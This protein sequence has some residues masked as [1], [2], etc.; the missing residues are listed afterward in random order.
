MVSY[1]WDTRGTFQETKRKPSSVQVQL[2][3]D[4]YSFCEIL[5]GF[6]FLWKLILVL[7]KGTVTLV[8]GIG[9]NIVFLRIVVLWRMKIQTSESIIFNVA[10]VTKNLNIY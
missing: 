5:F 6:T 8:F 1:I 3:S 4:R 10:E 9:Y 2:R 7:V